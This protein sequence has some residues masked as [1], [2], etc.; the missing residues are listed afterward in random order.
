MLSLREQEDLER[1]AREL[2]DRKVERR[3]EDDEDELSADDDEFMAQYR[4]E[5][6]QVPKI[7]PKKLLFAG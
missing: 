1:R 2:Q 6:S 5:N 4:C 3:E 7:A